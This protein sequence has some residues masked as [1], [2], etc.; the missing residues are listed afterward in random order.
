MEIPVFADNV[1]IQG[2]GTEVHPLTSI[3]PPV[4]SGMQHFRVPFT[5]TAALDAAHCFIIPVVFPIPFPDTLYTL[6]VTLELGSDDILRWVP[7]HNYVAGDV[8]FDPTTETIQECVVAGLSLG[9]AP[10]FST[11]LGGIV[12]E[13]GGST[14]SWQNI[15]A[16]TY[17]IDIQEKTVA[18]FSEMMLSQIGVLTLIP[19]VDIPMI[20]HVLAI[21]D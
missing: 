21:H 18:G 15:T 6:E 4:I 17:E 13:G 20:L 12:N 2:D 19:P 1:T 10:A 11:L 5:L 16:L 7:N 3:T 14:V 8:V 9:V